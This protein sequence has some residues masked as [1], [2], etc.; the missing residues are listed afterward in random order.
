M[1]LSQA[2]ALISA[3]T[4]L[5]GGATS[6]YIARGTRSKDGREAVLKEISANEEW[7]NDRLQ[8]QVELFIK[9]LQTEVAALRA[10]V[11]SLRRDIDSER[12]KYWR[13]IKTIRSLYE[14][15]EGVSSPNSPPDPHPEIADDI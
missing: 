13:A 12:N 10:E 8:A 4:L 1:D 11:S 14:W 7:W 3:I 5:I 15:A 6:W 9:P 2:V